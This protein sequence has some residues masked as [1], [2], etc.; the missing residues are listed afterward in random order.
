MILKGCLINPD[1]Q[2]AHIIFSC[3]LKIDSAR[4]DSA[5][6]IP[7][8]PL[9]AASIGGKERVSAAQF[10]RYKPFCRGRN[11]T[12][13]TT[14]LLQTCPF[15]DHGAPSL[16]QCPGHVPQGPDR[17]SRGH[18]ARLGHVVPLPLLYRPTVLSRDS[19][20]FLE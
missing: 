19:I 5:S 18:Q 2:C 3:R 15:S 17:P 16:G 14:F 12:A 20:L 1:L 13:V 6:L 9:F 11:P 10:H 7:H 4:G 8:S